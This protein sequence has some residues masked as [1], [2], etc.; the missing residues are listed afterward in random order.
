MKL[1]TR[2]VYVNL[3]IIMVIMITIVSYLLVANYTF[4]KESAIREVQLYTENKASDME[5]ILDDALHN[6]IAL[7]KTMEV[8]VKSEEH[9]R[10]AVVEYLKDELR[11]NTQYLDIWVIFEKNAFDNNDVMYKGKE[12]NDT[13][14]RFI[15]LVTHDKGD[16]V[17]DH[18]KAIE[19]NDYYDIPMKTGEVYVSKPA[20]WI[21]NNEEITSITMSQPIKKNGKVVGVAGFDISLATLKEISAKVTFYETGFGR[22][23]TNEGIIIAHPE[24]ERLNK[25]GGE[26][27]GEK[28][29]EILAEIN[30]GNSF[31]RSAW[32]ESMQKEVQKVYAPIHFENLDLKW[33]YSAIVPYNEM[34]AKAQSLLRF[35]IIFGFIGIAIMAIVVYKNSKY[36]VNAV[37]LISQA[38]S[39]LARYDLHF[40]GNHGAAKLLQR[41]DETGEMARSLAV[42]E[43]NFATLIKQAQDVSSQVSASSEELTATA[44][45]VASTSEDVARTI[46]EVSRG[47]IQQAEDTEMG[48]TKIVE[49][50]DLINQNQLYM[51]EVNNSSNNVY[52]LIDVGLEVIK[53]MTEKTK[54]SGQV[55]SEIFESISETNTSSGKIGQASEMIASI[56]EQTNLLALNAAIEAARAG[57]AGKGFAVVADEIR[58]LAEQSTAST[59]EI[60]KVVNELLVNSSGAVEKMEEVRVIVEKQIESVTETEKKYNEISKAVNTT[61]DAVEKMSHSGEAM[62][63][64]KTS[65]LEIIESLSAMAEENGASSQ[66]ASGATEE[67]L[68]SIQEMANASGGLAELATELQMT[69]SKFKL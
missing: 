53:D 44:Q 46:D 26:F 7:G 21:V 66:E 24:A 28:G 37:T 52:E 30:K 63:A 23:I 59:K 40:D 32:S 54:K 19:G 69:I 20:T 6:T 43:E 60:D 4:S 16:V 57:E 48:A 49:L 50:G 15:P 36:V 64:G 1:K 51:N 2:L 55:T 3:G 62:E 47:A 12:G 13:K 45:E 22:L 11:G 17:L 35:A 29:E 33:S 38:A 25:I 42:M 10:E 68:S 14:G 39:K 18:I 27:V 5:E 65:I 34:M 61:V 9:D 8:M 41:K 58:K 56:A 67:Q 31:V